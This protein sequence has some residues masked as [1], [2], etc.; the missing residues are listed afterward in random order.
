[1]AFTIIEMVQHAQ[2]H[3]FSTHQQLVFAQQAADAQEFTVAALCVQRAQAEAA[4]G[5]LALELSKHAWE[6]KDYTEERRV[7]V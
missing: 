4:A 7:D 6:Q 1:M 2:L 3:Y 5:L